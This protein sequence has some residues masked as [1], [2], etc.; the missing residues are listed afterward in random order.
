[1]GT[2]KVVEKE[3][4]NHFKERKLPFIFISVFQI[5]DQPHDNT[6]LIHQ[7]MS[8]QDRI[9]KRQRQ[10]DKN[11][12]EQNNGIV[13]SGKHFTKEQ[14]AEAVEE[15]RSGGGLY[16]PDGNIDGSY[17]RDNAPSLSGDVFN[18]LED[19]RSE[20]RNIFGVTGLSSQGLQGDQTVRGKILTKEADGS[21][22]GGGITE[23]IEMAIDEIFNWWVQLMFVY[24]SDEDRDFTTLGS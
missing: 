21:R 11:V 24:Y 13:L 1:M 20:L 2:E 3:G 18:N 16:V 9:N 6:S 4:I 10:I 22:V 5:G 14:A 8:N 19:T 23:Y 17:K 15:L 7:N 12:D